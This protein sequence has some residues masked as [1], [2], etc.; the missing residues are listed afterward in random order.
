LKKKKKKK[1]TT[2]RKKRK[3]MASTI[4]I[5][6]KFLEY[7]FQLAKLAKCDAKDETD[8]YTQSGQA[9]ALGL[10]GCKWA[11]GKCGLIKLHDILKRP[12]AVNF[13]EKQIRALSPAER[14]AV[15]LNLVTGKTKEGKPLIRE[16]VTGKKYKGGGKQ[17]LARGG[18]RGGISQRFAQ[19]VL[20]R[21]REPETKSGAP[22]GETKFP[23][24]QSGPYLPRYDEDSYDHWGHDDHHWDHDD[25]HDDY[26]RHYGYRRSHYD[27]EGY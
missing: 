17:R 26:R 14:D 2:E 3:K 9:R 11:K 19:E 27:D 8:C 24:V 23:T 22:S 4:G 20:D 6:P 18:E 21:L 12:E 10:D 1:E 13:V 15:M 5:D 16:Y 25:D 7:K